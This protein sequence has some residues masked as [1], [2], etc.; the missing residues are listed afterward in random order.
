[1]TAYKGIEIGFGNNHFGKALEYG[2]IV[3]IDYVKTEG[4]NGNIL[5]GGV[6]TK[7]AE[8]LIDEAGNE[9]QL[10]CTNMGTLVGGADYEI[11]DDIRA[12][13]PRAYQTFERAITAADYKYLLE[14]QKFVDKAYI[15]GEKEI[16]EDVGNKPGTFLLPSENVVYITGFAIDSLTSYGILPSDTTITKMRQ[17]LNDKKGVTDILQFVPTQFIYVTFESQVFISDFQYVAEQV[18]AYIAQALLKEFCVGERQ[19]RKNLYFSDYYKAI[20]AVAGVDHHTTTLLL[21]EMYHFSS[22]YEFTANLEIAKIAPGSV[23]IKLR[24]VTNNLDWTEIA[25]DDGEGNIVGAPLDPDAPEDGVYNIPAAAISYSDGAIGR[26]I[27]TEGALGFHY[28]SY[29][30]RI[31]FRLDE[32]ENGNVVLTKRNQILGYYDERVAVE[33]MA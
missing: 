21:S 29:D 25:Y 28:S 17:Y 24:S 4:K 11:I 14:R 20:D 19:Y 12:K 32:S 31:D 6:V 30:I 16:N 27:I 15:W 13:A 9:V 1:M 7:V 18:T 3:T 8:T 5:S 2:D 33:Y 10:H 23:S 22:A 26:V